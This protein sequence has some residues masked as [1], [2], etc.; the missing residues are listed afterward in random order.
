MFIYKFL[1]AALDFFVADSSV[2]VVDC[3]PEMSSMTA[4]ET[5][6]GVEP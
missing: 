1:T 5:A 6:K 4:T 2:T 3:E